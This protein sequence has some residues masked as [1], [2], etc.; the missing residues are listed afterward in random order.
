M[1]NSKA[2]LNHLENNVVTIRR[3]EENL[4]NLMNVALRY[5]SN[6]PTD[7]YYNTMILIENMKDVNRSTEEL[8]CEMY[9]RQ[10]ALGKAFIEES[11]AVVEIAEEK[12]SYI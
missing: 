3:I 4:M 5:Q 12:C 9:T 10:T 6:A 8:L 1:M 11:D 2:L 7:D